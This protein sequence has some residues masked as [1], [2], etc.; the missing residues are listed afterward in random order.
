MYCTQT[1]Y[2]RLQCWDRVMLTV[3]VM[4]I[5]STDHNIQGY[6]NGYPRFDLI[7]RDLEARRALAFSS[8][9]DCRLDRIIR[10]IWIVRRHCARHTGH[11]LYS[12]QLAISRTTSR[13]LRLSER[14]L[15][16]PGLSLL[17]HLSNFASQEILHLEN[18]VSRN[19]P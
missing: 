18:C 4:A 9:I 6:G 2:T 12:F 1:S 7:K 17:L 8:I 3:Q 19:Q 10:G 16:S 5:H 14:T 13:P 11:P 15:F